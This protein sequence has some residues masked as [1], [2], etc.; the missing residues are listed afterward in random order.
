MEA[1]SLAQ[2]QLQLLNK[3]LNKYEK[4][5]KY[6]FAIPTGIFFEHPSRCIFITFRMVYLFTSVPLHTLYIRT[7]ASLVHCMFSSQND[8][9][10][11]K[12]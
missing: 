12:N 11:N 2:K 4:V 1:K 7:I 6:M 9:I 3:D 10:R 5:K 8:L